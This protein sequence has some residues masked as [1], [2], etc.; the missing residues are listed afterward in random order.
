MRSQS[1]PSLECPDGTCRQNFADLDTFHGHW[2]EHRDQCPFPSCEIQPNSKYNFGR[3]CARAHSDHFVEYQSVHQTACK[4]LCGKLYSRANV[5]NL[6]RHE[7]TCCGHRSRR[8]PQDPAI[9]VNLVND[10][11]TSATDQGSHYGRTSAT[12]RF[13]SQTSAS[14]TSEYSPSPDRRVSLEAAR[15]FGCWRDSRP[16]VEA[17]EKLQQVL[18]GGPAAAAFKAF[19]VSLDNLGPF[20]QVSKHSSPGE[21]YEVC[22]GTLIGQLDKTVD[23][24]DVQQDDRQSGMYGSVPE[25]TLTPLSTS[26]KRRTD[27]GDADSLHPSFKRQKPVEIQGSDQ[28]STTLDEVENSDSFSYDHMVDVAAEVRLTY[29]CRQIDPLTVIKT[30]NILRSDPH[31]DPI[32]FHNDVFINILKSQ[33]WK[34]FAYF[35]LMRLH[36]KITSL[37][38]LFVYRVMS[39][40]RKLNRN[41]NHNRKLGSQRRTIGLALILAERLYNAKVGNLFWAEMTGI[42][43]DQIMI[44]ENRFCAK[45]SISLS[46]DETSKL[47]DTVDWLSGR[48]D[49][50]RIT[51]LQSNLA[52]INGMMNEYLRDQSLHP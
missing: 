3:H 29:D 20:T 52:R 9:R 27:I 48:H 26:S 6:K 25:R 21:L 24:A 10:D 22:E 42:P 39:E 16:I 38:L 5:S 12:V 31:C 33:I 13:F 46:V 18:A 23:L 47:S 2:K 28:T 30:I 11:A 34:V 50:F 4:H 36:Q 43:L 19:T 14:G 32:S 1:P 35:R 44:M 51:S 40:T 45:I 49:E 7:K 17:M 8:Q 15:D 41:H 37:A